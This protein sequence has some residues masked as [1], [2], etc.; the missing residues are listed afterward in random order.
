M[1][2]KNLTIQGIQDIQGGGDEKGKWEKG[3]PHIKRGLHIAGFHSLFTIH[4]SLFSLFLFP[5]RMSVSM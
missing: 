2:Q 3:L 1:V 4:N 5:F